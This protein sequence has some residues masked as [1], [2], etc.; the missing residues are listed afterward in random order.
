MRIK[1]SNWRAQFIALFLCVL[2]ARLSH[3]DII[4]FTMTNI[5]T[6]LPDTNAIILNPLLPEVGASGQYYTAGLPVLLN[7]N[8][9][10]FVQTTQYAGF[11]NANNQ[12]ISRNWTGAGSP[13]SFSGVSF[14]V[15]SNGTS[16]TYPFTQY[17]LSGSSGGANV[18]NLY[19]GILAVHGINGIAASTIAGVVTIDGAGFTATITYASI[20]NGLGYIP[21][22]TNFVITEIVNT[23]NLGATG[24]NRYYNNTNYDAFGIGLLSF[25][26]ASNM[27]LTVLGASNTIYEAQITSTSNGVTTAFQNALGATNTTIQGQITSTTNGLATLVISATNGLGLASGLSAFVSTNRFDTANAALNATNGIDLNSGLS[28]FASTNRF[29]QAATT[30]N[31]GSSV[32]NLVTAPASGLTNFVAELANGKLTPFPLTSLPSGGTGGGVTS[33]VETNAGP[34]AIGGSILYSRT[35][36]DQ[37]P[38]IALLTGAGAS[39]NVV[40]TSNLLQQQIINSNTVYQAQILNTSNAIHSVDSTTS[41]L[42]QQAIISSNTVYQSQITGTSN[43]LNSLIGS[44]WVG[45]SNQLNT[46]ASGITNNN[47]YVNGMTNGQGIVNLG[48][49]NMADWRVFTNASGLIISNITTAQYFFV[50]SIASGNNALWGSTNNNLVTSNGLFLGALTEVQGA[51][52]PGQVFISNL[53][54]AAG[55]SIYI[56]GNTWYMLGGGLNIGT[57]PF[58]ANLSTSTNLGG[59]GA[60]IQGGQQGMFSGGGNGGAN[61]LTN[62]IFALASTNNNIGFVMTNGIA[63]NTLAIVTNIIQL[64]NN[65]IYTA[66]GAS[67]AIY[68]PQITSTSNGVT[69]LT[70]PLANTN[71]PTIWNMVHNGTLNIGG[72]PFQTVSTAHLGVTNFSSSLLSMNGGYEQISSTIWYDTNSQNIGYVATIIT[73]G[74]SCLFQSNAITVATAGNNII[75]AYTTI[76]PGSGNNPGVFFGSVILANG[77]RIQGQLVSD[78]LRATNFSDSYGSYPASTN[79]ATISGV[80]TNLYVKVIPVYKI[81]YRGTNF[82]VAAFNQSYTNWIPV[83]F[84]TAVSQPIFDYVGMTTPQ[85]HFTN[86]YGDAGYALGSNLVSSSSPFAFYYLN[87][88][89]PV[90]TAISNAWNDDAA[91]VNPG[92]LIP[93]ILATNYITVPYSVPENQITLQTNG[94]DSLALP[95]GLSFA[96]IDVANI[97]YPLPGYYFQLD[98][99]FYPSSFPSFDGQFNLNPGQGLCGSPSGTTIISGVSLAL[100]TS[101]ILQ[102]LTFNNGSQIYGAV[103]APDT[104]ISEAIAYNTWNNISVLQTNGQNSGDCMALSQIAWCTFNNVTL[105]GWENAF[106]GYP[107]GTNYI[108]NCFFYGITGT[109]QFDAANPFNTTAPTFLGAATNGIGVFEIANTTIAVNNVAASGNNT[110]FPAAC[111]LN[112]CTNT[113]FYFNGGVNLQHWGL[114]TNYPAIIDLTGT[115]KFYGHYYDNGTDMVVNGLLTTAH[116]FMGTITNTASPYLAMS[117]LKTNLVSGYVLVSLQMTNG[118]SCA[119]TNLTAPNHPWINI[120]D[121]NPQTI[122]GA[123][124]HSIS[125][126]MFVNQG[127]IILLTNTSTPQAAVSNCWLQV[128][129]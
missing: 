36:F 55:A 21:A 19:S 48:N 89:L 47:L 100:S 75:G 58:T 111:I 101:N 28:A 52:L 68:E 105:V 62:L 106:Q 59:T 12:F 110:N 123:S 50:L 32:S 94:V 10:G 39:N 95:G 25:Q 114:I 14:A 72:S 30:V 15:L 92:T 77:V 84:S 18:F 57:M 56:V 120:E 119:L 90:G 63:S 5:V 125:G 86:D 29:L 20:T 3:A 99:T 66:I 31:D 80:G 104:T 73:N 4:T 67:N 93:Y 40:T 17:P 69:A 43:G 116:Q 83:S 1:S 34:S 42:L 61:A 45:T 35:N 26:S 16:S 117:V 71:G 85:L 33:V 91:T 23:N 115:A 81:A 11:W 102:N 78:S 70:Y 98:A 37:P 7:P 79:I 128:P 107:I 13:G 118:E 27:T 113:T 51:S 127:D 22:N 9:S 49:L 53:T 124:V 88:G 103:E 60:A 82:T 6:G 54:N 122:I 65:A 44:S 38:G 2:C 8:A 126:G 87:Q 64:T 41:N 96:N 24:G 74:S 46:L 112:H 76:A 108:N 121:S 97:A 129:N 109:N